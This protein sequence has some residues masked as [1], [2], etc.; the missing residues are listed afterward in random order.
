M[1][2]LALGLVSGAAWGR[3]GDE[4][5]CVDLFEG[6]ACTRDD[7]SEGTCLPDDS[8]PDVLKCDDDGL[9]GGG[10]STSGGSL[11]CATGGAGA[12]GWL[13]VSM[14]LLGTRRGR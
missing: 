1:L 6:D 14:L 5:A 9:S 7:G 13:A 4:E 10:T 2:M 3:E 11:S 12:L 8:D